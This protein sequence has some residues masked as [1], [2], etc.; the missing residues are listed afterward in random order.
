MLVEDE[1][2]L[3]AFPFLVVLLL[4]G[5]ATTSTDGGS[6]GT[7]ADP[8]PPG[9]DDRT[10]AE[11]D[12]VEEAE[13]FFGAGA[14][15]LADVL[16]KV[17]HEHGRPQGLI[18][19]TEGGGALGIGLR[20]GEG[21]LRMARGETRKVYWNGPSIGFDAGGN[22]AKVVVL[23]YHL[24]DVDDLFQ[25]YPGVEGSAYFVG[26]VGAN[27]NRSGGTVLAPVRF[28]VGWR[29]GASVGYM[30]FTLQKNLIPF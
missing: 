29:L 18:K 19:G 5:C 23:V 15:G 14:E 26:G 13:E 16:H 3:R 10:I 27:Y 24:R 9:A 11:S 7:S 17:F 4:A 2:M 30:K 12:V 8:P 20:Y 1:T 6:A 22:L 21:L 28:G 25:R